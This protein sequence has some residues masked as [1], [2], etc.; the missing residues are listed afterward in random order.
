[1]GPKP[2]RQADAARNAPRLV[3]E[4][5]MRCSYGV[6]C[7]LAPRIL[8]APNSTHWL[9]FPELYLPACARCFL[10][11]TAYASVRASDAGV[12]GSR[13]AA[14]APASP[15]AHAPTLALGS[16]SSDL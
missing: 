8:A 6:L 5:T 11:R 3:S 7:A 15:P 13:E 1:M 4:R 12:M 14:C 2:T 9:A 10:S 16:C